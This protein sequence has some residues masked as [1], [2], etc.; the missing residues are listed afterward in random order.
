MADS[1]LYP[2][3]RPSRS[4]RLIC[5]SSRRLRAAADYLD[6]IPLKVIR[7]SHA[8]ANRELQRVIKRMGLPSRREL[9][10]TKLSYLIAAHYVAK[11]PVKDI[12]VTLEI[13][14]RTVRRFV[15]A[16]DLPRRHPAAFGRMRNGVRLAGE[17]EAEA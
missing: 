10:H 17:V 16:L 11:M 1:T 12:A 3:Q 7:E 15:R 14:E 13:S 5:R 2:A 9:R 4:G 6:D 8:I